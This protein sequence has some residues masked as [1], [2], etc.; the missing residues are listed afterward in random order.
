LTKVK[1]SCERIQHYGQR[2]DERGDDVNWDDAKCL[3][4]IKDTLA[5]LREEYADAERRLR[6]FYGS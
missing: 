4:K 3:S 5:A 6:A 2:K 1:D